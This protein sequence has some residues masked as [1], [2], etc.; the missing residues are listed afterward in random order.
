MLAS[1]FLERNNKTP[2]LKRPK[3]T[4][5]EP[6]VTTVD[7]ERARFAALSDDQIDDAM[8]TKPSEDNLT[9][10]GND[11]AVMMTIFE[12]EISALTARELDEI[13]VKY[14]QG[15]FQV[16]RKEILV[17]LLRLGDN[18]ASITIK[19]A[20]AQSLEAIMISFLGRGA[21]DDSMLK[22]YEVWS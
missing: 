16:E 21:A 5:M 20:S 7:V 9:S 19:P 22:C 4:G 11:T 8:H 2:R 13:Y 15:K 14:S 1:I 10:Y 6:I 3:N 12:S 17:N 18:A